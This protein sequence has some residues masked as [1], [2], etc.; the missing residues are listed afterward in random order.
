MMFSQVELFL[1]IFPNDDN[2]KQAS[3][4]LISATFY[5]VEC[6]IGFFI[7]SLGKSTWDSTHSPLALKF[8]HVKLKR[9]YN[10]PPS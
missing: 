10:P 1:E 4:K 6:V 9:T 2:I 5:A 7:S 8:V 3:V